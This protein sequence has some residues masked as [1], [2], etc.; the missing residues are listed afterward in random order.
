M[1]KSLRRRLGP[2]SLSVAA[3]A[4]TAVAFAA[5]S[6]AKDDSK[7]EAPGGEGA[8]FQH[9]VGPPE[10]SEEQEQQLDQF[11]Q[12]MEDQGAPVPPKPGEIEEGDRPEPPTEEEREQ[13][14]EAF[15]ACEDKLPE[16]A[17]LHFGPGGPPCGPPPGARGED[18]EGAVLPAP[19]PGAPGAPPS[20]GD[21]SAP[22]GASS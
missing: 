4:L 9:R 17:G 15:E 7:G 12:C 21:E 6:V 11:R 16:G 19:P 22:G 10:L 20:G 5:V 2:V 14:E 1:I 13:I 18:G 3:A 8:V